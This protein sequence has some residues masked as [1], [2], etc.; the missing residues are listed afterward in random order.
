MSCFG[1]CLVHQV[2]R[3]TPVVLVLMLM[4]S[5]MT[6]VI[7]SGVGRRWVPIS[8]GAQS[9]GSALVRDRALAALPALVFMWGCLGVATVAVLSMDMRVFRGLIVTVPLLGACCAIL[10]KSPAVSSAHGRL[11][12]LRSGA[13]R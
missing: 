5:T 11:A 7:V 2:A 10:A 8:A 12:A 6:F 4:A 1:A 9:G 3:T 13:A